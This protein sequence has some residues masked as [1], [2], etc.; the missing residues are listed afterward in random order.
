MTDDSPTR[1]LAS[2]VLA[3]VLVAAVVTTGAAGIGTAAATGHL[4][5]GCADGD[6]GAEFVADGGL[7]VSDDDDAAVTVNPIVN[8]TA[9]A[10]GNVTVLA[11][12]SSRVVIEAA[13]ADRVCTGAVNASMTPATLAPDGFGSATVEG[14]LTAFA[15]GPANYSDG[16]TDLLYNASGPVTV[17]LGDAPSSS[18]GVRAVDADTGESLA[19][20]TAGADATVRLD[21]PA[22]VHGVDLQTVESGPDP[23]LD[24]ALSVSLA[25]ATVT[26]NDSSS[27][28][29]TV[30]N[31]TSGAP[32]SGVT[33]AIPALGQGATTNATGVAEFAVAAEAGTYSVVASAAGFDDGTATLTVGEAGVP[34]DAVYEP[35]S[36]A[37]SYD[38]AGDSRDGRIVV[39]E[40]GAAAADYATG[41]LTIAEL[42]DIA[43]AYARS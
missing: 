28:A 24:P 29:A 27:V 19:N 5:L 9:L 25:P 43:A 31:A 16:T 22:G 20:A 23:G 11:D 10:F 38:G 26:A 37:A 17:A 12:G 13:T 3:A 36:T 42:G 30:T 1:L 7:A 33:V 34:P 21:L 2:L 4:T 40:L 14:S 15:Y 32:V 6:T 8:D 18:T 39:T 35:D 41:E